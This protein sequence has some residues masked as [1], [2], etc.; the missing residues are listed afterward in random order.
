MRVLFLTPERFATV[1]LPSYPDIRLAIA[2]T[3]R[4]AGE[5]GALAPDYIHIATEGPLGMAARRA[6][7]QQGLAFTTAYH[8]RFPEFIGA[9]FP[10]P[11]RLSYW[12]LRRFHNAG[13]GM[14]VATA[15]L[16]AEMA[17]RGFR[18][19]KRWSRGVDTRLFDP[20]RRQDLGLP[21][22]V[23]LNVGRVAVEKNLPAFLSLDLPGSK[24]VVGDGPDLP[25]LRKR[26]PDVHFL[27]RR[28]GE[29]L[30]AVYASA[31]AFVFPSRTDTFGNV[32]LEA[33]ASGLPVAAFPV[34]APRDILSPGGG[35]LAEDLRTAA[36]AALDIPR[37]LARK[38][39][40]TYSWSA[41]AHE[42]LGNLTPAT[43]ARPSRRAPSGALSGG[44]E[45][46]RDEA[47]GGGSW[48]SA[49]CLP[50]TTG[51]RPVASSL[52]SSTPHWSKELMLN[53]A[54]STKTRC[55]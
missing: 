11:E 21:R 20:G 10:V 24:V 19:I 13:N 22:P 50:S 44:P 43:A 15:S 55:S 47:G 45:Q 12:W 33:L 31:D 1:P 41:C 34:T 36:L 39:A 3:R 49:L 32:I 35:A 9:R 40:L 54:P 46:G 2:T 16:G 30:A 23:F 42:F 28:T 17:T 14:M 51:S 5:I 25:M 29:D 8:T 4:V 53:S 38:R 7:L 26:Y 37:D 52:P 27:G 48:P 18:R 6:C